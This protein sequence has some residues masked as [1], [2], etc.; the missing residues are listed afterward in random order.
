MATNNSNGTSLPITSATPV[1]AA[2]FTPIAL[3]AVSKPS[4]PTTTSR[5]PQPSLPAAGQKRATASAS[6]LLS[7][8]AEL[9]RVS[10]IIQPIWKPVNGPKASRVYR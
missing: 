10:Q 3:M 5:R 7:A 8:A 4:E 6:P 2:D 1:R 9:M